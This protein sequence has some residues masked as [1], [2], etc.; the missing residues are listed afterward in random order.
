MEIMERNGIRNRHCGN[1]TRDSLIKQGIPA[2]AGGWQETIREAVN[3]IASGF[4]FAMTAR[5]SGF[6]FAMTA[7][8][9]GFAF[10]G[11]TG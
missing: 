8:P 10:A 9:S 1:L 7:R 5:P 11:M 4:A 2:F 3:W 6:A